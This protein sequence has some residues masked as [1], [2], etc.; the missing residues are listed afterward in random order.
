M[1]NPLQSIGVACDR[2]L[3]VGNEPILGI[4]R[5][6]GQQQ[7]VGRDL[8]VAGKAIDQRQPAGRVLL[9]L[10]LEVMRQPSLGQMHKSSCV[11]M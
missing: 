11:D 5:K 10:A 4:L 9:S 7:N 8:K 1:E 6:L 3:A 2:C